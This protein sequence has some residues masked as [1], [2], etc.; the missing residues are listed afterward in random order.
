MFTKRPYIRNRSDGFPL[1]ITGTN[2]I[3]KQQGDYTG[4]E[5]NAQNKTINAARQPRLLPDEA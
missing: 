2:G 5:S 4:Y 3:L 1:L